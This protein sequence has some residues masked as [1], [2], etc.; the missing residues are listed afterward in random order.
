M[1]FGR[2]RKG[3]IG[4]W[5]GRGIL[6]RSGGFG[7]SGLGGVVGRRLGGMFRRSGA[8]GE[9]RCWEVA[10]DSMGIL[11]ERRDGSDR[12]NC[13]VE[14]TRSEPESLTYI[15]KEEIPTKFSFKRNFFLPNVHLDTTCQ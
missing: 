15:L 12:P 9:L 13:S 6:E 4:R 11:G 3:R 5:R 1:L 2:L 7:R 14:C 10:G 8:I